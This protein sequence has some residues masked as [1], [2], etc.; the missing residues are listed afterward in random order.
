MKTCNDCQHHLGNN[1]CSKSLPV[2][3]NIKAETCKEFDQKLHNFDSTTL[4]V[5]RL[6]T[7]ERVE[8]GPPSYMK[9]QGKFT[10]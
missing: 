7:V 10:Q 1:D 3:Y 6:D 4:T 5:T 2:A 8:I 9:F